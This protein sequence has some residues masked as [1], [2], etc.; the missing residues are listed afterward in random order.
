MMRLLGLMA[1]SVRGQAFSVYLCLGQAANTRPDILDRRAFLPEVL[2]PAV[3]RALTL[4]AVRGR[5][6]LSRQESAPTLC[7]SSAVAV[8]RHSRLGAAA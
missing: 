3:V 1:A 8:R 6:A 4:F 7:K 5:R 2:P